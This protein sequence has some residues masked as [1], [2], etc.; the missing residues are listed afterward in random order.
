MNLPPKLH[1]CLMTGFG[2]SLSLM[3]LL[4]WAPAEYG[5][6]APLPPPL[7]PEVWA[8]SLQQ[9][10]LEPLSIG[11]PMPQSGDQQLLVLLVDFADRPGLF[12]GQQWRDSFF[13]AAGFA[14][15]FAETSYNQLRY[16]GD[17][18]GMD[19]ATPV[20]NGQSVSYI[21][22]P[23]PITFYT[24]GLYGFRTG[25]NQFPRNNAGV[26]SHAL[27]AL[28]KA[29]FDFAPYADP[30]TQ[31]VEN[32][33]IVFAGKPHVYTRDN[34]NSLEATGY[35]LAAAGA[36][37]FVSSGGQTF[38]NFTFCPD[39]EGSEPGALA[40]IGICVHEHG[41][42]LGLPDLYDFSYLT[43]GV[44]RYDA[45]SYGAYGVTSGLR[46]FHLGAFSKEFLGWVQ[47][48]LVLSSTT[49]VALGPAETEPAM[50]K[51]APNG[52]VN[53]AEYFLL[54]N[55]QPLGF[56]QDW[57]SGGYCPGLY[58][59]H[60]DQNVVAQFSW[61]NLVN[62]PLLANGP[63]H[64]GVT[65]VEADGGD[66]LIHVPFTYGECSDAWAVDQ[67]W[68][69]ATSPS[70]RLWTNAD[71]GISLTVESMQNG[72]VTLTIA[73]DNVA[74]V[75]GTPTVS[76]STTVTTTPVLSVTATPTA[77]PGA[78]VTATES[79]TETPAATPMPATPSPVDATS[80]P[81]STPTVL[82]SGPRKIYLPVAYH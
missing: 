50:V 39:E 65:V 49:V 56:D 61:T 42:S 31:R 40:H 7:A 11:E 60:V 62:S 3:S 16:T 59:W 27:Q 34:V 44:G 19:G 8:G 33:L 23:N 14:A 48:T 70:T 28:D 82:A 79:Q 30:T 46:P 43:S 75:G 25:A 26:V 15:Y 20:V 68:N 38:D 54:E 17:I 45:M 73:L 80:T 12:T 69:S 53:S 29:G 18:V 71:S 67:M 55:R 32:L 1:L 10:N 22:L 4:A 77:T 37:L 24:D 66:D 36:P 51:L 21:R 74:P 78:V 63:K 72:I 13:G 35:S 2:L 52:Q 5:P 41:H 81:Q 57:L 64:P 47:P 76:P 9:N 6:V 58:I